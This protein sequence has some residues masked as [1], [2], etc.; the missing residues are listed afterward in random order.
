VKYVHCSN[1]CEI[2]RLVVPEPGT[3]G[4]WQGCSCGQAAGRMMNKYEAE[5]MNGTPIVL[6]EFSMEAAKRKARGKF[7]GQVFK[8]LVPGTDDKRF[9]EVKDPDEASEC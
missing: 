9:S 5:Y 1:C 4:E 2:I 3:E 6:L 7:T 8:C